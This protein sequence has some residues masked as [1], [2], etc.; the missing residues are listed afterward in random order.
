MYT[1]TYKETSNVYNIHVL[2]IIITCTCTCTY[3]M[4]MYILHALYIICGLVLV[5]QSKSLSD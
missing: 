1:I 4:Y 2:T 5:S 3:H